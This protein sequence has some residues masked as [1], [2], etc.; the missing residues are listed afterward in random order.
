VSLE[1][2]AVTALKLNGFC[3]TEGVMDVTL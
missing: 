3:V 2:D 1:G